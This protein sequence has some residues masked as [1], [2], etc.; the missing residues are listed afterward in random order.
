MSQVTSHTRQFAL[1][2]I[3]F[4]TEG[5][6][7]SRTKPLDAFRDC[8]KLRPQLSP[9]M[10]SG[11]FQTLLASAE[12]PWLRAVQIKMDGTLEALGE[13]PTQPDPSDFFEGRIV[14]LAQ[15]LELLLAFIGQNL[16]WHLVHE[17]WPKVRLD[18]LG[19]M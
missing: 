8:E 14:L 3:A 9:L 6:K 15:M 11:G 17:T 19:L 12:V 2:I 18:D 10:G 7:P 16:T 13:L 4:D 5:N 1:R